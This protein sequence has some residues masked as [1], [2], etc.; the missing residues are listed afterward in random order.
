MTWGSRNN[1]LMTWECLL[2]TRGWAI[3]IMTITT[4]LITIIITIIRIRINNSK[5]NNTPV[6]QYTGSCRLFNIENKFP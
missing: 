1:K 5:Y 3:I 6:P 2:V 4:I